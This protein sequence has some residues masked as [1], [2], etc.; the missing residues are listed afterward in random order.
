MFSV[1]SVTAVAWR[2]APFVTFA[3]AMHVACVLLLI[4]MPAQWP[5]WLALV[6]VMQAML[7]VAAMLPRCGWA[8][9]NHTRLPAH[10]AGRIALTIDD[11]PDPEVTPRVL[12]LL[13]QLGVKATFFCVG[14]NARRHP[15]LCR[16][17]AA[18]G[19]HIGNHTE[20]HSAAFAFSG[21]GGYRREIE[22]AQRT[23]TEMS[24]M[25]PRFF[26]APAGIRS[27][28]LDPVL[29]ALGL[30]LVSWTR[31]GFDTR[32]GDADTV[33]RRLAPGVASRA[34]L[35]L[36]DGHAARTGAGVPVILEVLPRLIEIARA[37]GLRWVTLDEAFGGAREA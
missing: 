27:P 15:A 6:L 19:H 37:R 36:H 17:I 22:A 10:A 28:L 26:R 18:R 3:I 21:L 33:L 8:G 30:Q 32:C 13:E 14:E 16:D 9:V 1:N 23:L 12:A 29:H 35:L 5:W 31:R 11:G 4:A 24:G 2:P 34:I 25:T 7:T 20:R